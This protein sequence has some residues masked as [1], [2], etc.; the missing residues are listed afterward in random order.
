MT[1]AEPHERIQGETEAAVADALQHAHA[2]DRSLAVILLDAEDVGT[3]DRAF[4]YPAGADALRELAARVG[5]AAPPGTPS[6]RLTRERF[7]LL[8]AGLPD[9]PATLALAQTLVDAARAPVTVAGAT[10]PIDVTAGVAIARPGRA[11][12]AADLLR[13]ASVAAHA[14]R[15][16]GRTPWQLADPAAR[17]RTLREIQLQDELA[18]ALEDGQLALY[19]QPIVS[20]RRGTLLGIE[21]LV[22]WRHPTRGLI[23]PAQFLPAAEHS[24]L[25]V[26]IGDWA[27]AEVCQQLERWSARHPERVLPP[28]SLNISA[29]ELREEAFVSRF[30]AT[31]LATQVAPETIAIEIAEPGVLVERGRSDG[32][33]TELRRL[34]VRIVLDRFGGLD[35]SLAHLAVLPVD[36]L[37]L[38][39][40][41]LG[42]GSAAGESPIVE[43]IVGL[44]H[45][46]G[47]PITVPGIETEQQLAAVRALH[48]DAAQ[49]HLI[50][51]PA[52]A[53]SLLDL[54]ELELEIAPRGRGGTS[55]S[56]RETQD[57]LLSLSTVAAALG[58][59]PS[60]VR[61][62]ADQGVLPGTRTEGGHRRF[63]RA[64]VQR[65]A[66]ER[67]R[68]PQ[69]RPWELPLQ[70]LPSAATLLGNDGRTLVE[71]AARA[72]YDPQRPGWYAG[73]QGLARARGWLDALGAALSAGAPRDAIA[74]TAAFADAAE[75]GGATA[76]ET[77]RFLGQ[78]TAVTAH[79][80]VRARAGADE[81]RALQRLMSAA[82][83]AFLD[84]LGQ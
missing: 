7:V 8:C 40:A 34:G 65:L 76:S 43:A 1:A 49:G 64:D 14:A 38:D 42:D 83:E 17:Q 31:L 23:G 73:P 15:A 9:T 21:A 70:P 33:L 45:A 82:T 26:P 55:A 80:L 56:L 19:Y 72:I 84:R 67:Q 74:A 5:A 20:L 35:S 59:S 53:S 11:A 41:L 3:V 12:V 52:P 57:D 48:V 2:A 25:I 50:A 39:R 28:V 47:L 81:P 75:L 60:T 32:T 10:V 58:V 61:R 69:L 29:R 18:H 79:E 62:L 77:V 22:R 71:R 63:R 46:L 30:A 37:K 4:G 68:T 78:F 24:G 54:N 66:R 51:R 6:L 13:D 27:L 44:A 36:G 16:P